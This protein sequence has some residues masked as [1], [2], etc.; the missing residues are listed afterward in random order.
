[1]LSIRLLVP[2]LLAAGVLIAADPVDITPDASLKGWTRLPWTAVDGL[3]PKV[4]WRVDAAQHALICAGDGGHEWLRFD[5]E[6]G[7]YILEVDWRFTPKGPDEQKYNAGV[8]VRLSQFG[9]LWVQ[10][11][12]TLQGGWL[13]GNNLTT[14]GALK[15]FNLREQ[16]KENRVKPAGQWN[17]YELRV[18][19]DKITLAVNGAVVSEATGIALRRGYV[20]LEAEGFEVTF[21]NLK[22]TELK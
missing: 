8:G 4:Q 17:H 21:Q 13:F 16:M 7:D 15:R 20:G 22:L 12:T 5:K 1:M 9:E 3:Q 19:G 18:V 10:A 14:D 6:L 11:Q 2:A